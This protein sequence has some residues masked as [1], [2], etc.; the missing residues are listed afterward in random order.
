MGYN[1]FDP[2]HFSAIINFVQQVAEGYS[3]YVVVLCVPQS[4][5]HVL[6]L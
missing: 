5:R 4:M 6:T 1:P 2:F 3:K